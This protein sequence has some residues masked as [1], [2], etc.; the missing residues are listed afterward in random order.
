MNL[1]PTLATALANEARR[2]ELKTATANLE[3][4]VAAIASQSQILAQQAGDISRRLQTKK[5]ELAALEAGAG[6]GITED[7]GAREDILAAFIAQAEQ[8][9]TITADMAQAL[10]QLAGLTG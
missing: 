4:Q 7:F 2:V 5:A 6:P 9:G 10:R 1:D 3:G 8:A